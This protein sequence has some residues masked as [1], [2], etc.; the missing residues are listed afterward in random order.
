MEKRIQEYK[1]TRIHK[2]VIPIKNLWL[3]KGP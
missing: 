3:P 2:R 1:N